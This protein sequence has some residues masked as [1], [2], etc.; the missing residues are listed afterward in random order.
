M[1]RS[2]IF[3]YLCLLISISV[4]AQNSPQYNSAE[5]LQKLYKLN[6]VGSV[7]YVAAH[8]DDENTRLLAYLANER[9]LRTGYLSLTRG[10]GGQNLIG[11]E[12]GEQLGL[13]RTQELLA[14]RRT[15]GAEQFFTRANDFGYSKNPQETFGF[16]NKDS[17]L[18]DV[19]WVIRNFRPDVIICRFPTD[20]RGGHGHHT[21][22]AILAEEA[23][24]AAA[25]PNRF[26]EQLQYVQ[27][28][29]AKRVFWNSYNFGTTN[30]TTPEQMQ[31]NVGLFNP[32][33][34]KGYGEIAADSRSNHKSQGFGSARGRG[35]VIE[36]F[37]Q[38]KGD[39]VSRDLF[40]GI[41]QT[42]ERLVG[43]KKIQKLIDKIIEEFKPQSPERSVSGLVALYKT[44]QQLDET[45]A[46]L[47]YWKAQ[48]LKET[49]TLILTCAGLWMEAYAADYTAIPG[50]DITITAQIVNNNGLDAQ[51]NRINYLGKTDTICYIGWYPSRKLQG[52]DDKPKPFVFKPL[53]H[54]FTHTE[55]LAANT[56]Y[57]TPY[58]LR[59]NHT[60]GLYAVN[61]LLMIGKPENDPQVAVT[62][63]VSI[64]GLELAVKRPV[65]YKYTDPVKGE[66]YRPLEILPPATVNIAEQS[67]VFGDTTPQTVKFIVKANKNN[68]QGTLKAEI[69]AG[70]QITLKNAS[71][72]IA[73]KGEEQVLEAVLRATPNSVSSSIIASIKIDGKTYNKAIQRVQYDHIPYQFTLS[74][75]EAKLVSIPLQKTNITIGY[76]PGAGDE[77]ANCLR[78]IGYKVVDL[79]DDMLANDDLSKYGAIITGIR[80]YNTNARL[81][82]L[83]NRINEYI[84]NGGN[85]IVQYN[86]NSRVGPFAGKIGP[87]DFTISRNRVTD[88]TASVKFPNPEHPALT[89]PNKIGDTDFEGW[90]QERGIYFAT[91]LNE[92]FVPV[93]EMADPNEEAQT[94]SL[95]IAPYGKGNF[96]YTGLSFFRELPDG[97]PG[98][99]RLFVNLLSLPQNK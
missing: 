98:A 8:P 51:L 20:G 50:E 66:V 76:I 31:L 14:A 9:K 5:I 82:Q 94:G 56:L 70:W 87:Y 96:V 89:Y 47:R 45:D 95:I 1:K 83:N 91:E 68:V 92:N 84:N 23:Y 21:A 35:E 59:D 2:T 79:T 37:Q 17:I 90:V 12:L 3:L 88:E 64:D 36:Y 13:I 33:L 62:F 69:P 71:F 38:I 11:K 86:T 48:K 16:W 75:A 97:V 6:T 28:W 24:E 77:V 18:A 25:D 54:S 39:S 74:D 61:D 44:L 67:Y 49:E 99:Y 15:D 26:P 22:S 19:V 30:T 10:D 43:T 57:S 32:L 41:N 29:Q 40:E 65:V 73:N 85:F 4:K 27:V 58:W 72:S 63:Y 46:A 7:L 80:A 52:K 60:L 42:W 81:L 93:L 34:G 55:K 53:L 78:L